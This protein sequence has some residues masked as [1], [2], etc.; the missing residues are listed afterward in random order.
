VRWARAPGSRGSRAGRTLRGLLPPAFD[1]PVFAAAGRME[2]EECLFD[3]IDSGTKVS[4]SFQVSTGGF[5]D[6]D[7][8]VPPPPA[9]GHIRAC[10]CLRVLHSRGL[11]SC[12]PAGGW[13]GRQGHLQCA[14][15]DRGAIH[16][17]CARVGCLPVLLQQ[18][19]VYGD[20]EDCFI[21][22]CSGGGKQERASREIRSAR[23]SAW[24]RMP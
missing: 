24:C 20:A 15:G 13:S 7:A 19:N 23:V 9:P 22:P 21:H 6:I 4:G 10:W 3:D 18:C 1:R 2:Q 14:E 12:P 17:H 11:T 5:L 16:F 8:K